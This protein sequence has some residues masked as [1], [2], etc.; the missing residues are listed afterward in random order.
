M[1]TLDFEYW[2][3][4]ATTA[5]ACFIACDAS[6]YVHCYKG[7]EPKWDGHEWLPAD[8][9]VGYA[10]R[11]GAIGDGPGDM[12]DWLSEIDGDFD[13]DNQ[14][15]HIVDADES[16]L[17][18]G[19]LADPHQLQYFELQ[20]QFVARVVGRRDKYLQLQDPLPAVPLRDWDFFIP[21]T[22]WKRMGRIVGPMIPT[23]T[24]LSTPVSQVCVPYF[25]YDLVEPQEPIE[26][27]IRRATAAVA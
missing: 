22:E 10:V 12:C 17:Y 7:E 24:G 19:E 2:S 26:D 13:E 27:V 5:E 11:L 9:L 4:R 6:G 1:A 20:E 15:D 21:A 23:R 18:I 25:A 16:L 3:R 14:E 8:P